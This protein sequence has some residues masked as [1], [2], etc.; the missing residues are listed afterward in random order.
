MPWLLTAPI[1]PLRTPDGHLRIKARQR[2]DSPPAS[3]RPVLLATG[4]GTPRAATA[5]TRNSKPPAALPRAHSPKVR[6]L[7][8]VGTPSLCKPSA[9]FRE[10]ARARAGSGPGMPTQCPG[11][12]LHRQGHPKILSKIASQK[13]SSGPA[14]ERRTSAPPSAR[15]QGQPGTCPDRTRAIPCTVQAV[16]GCQPLCA[17]ADDVLDRPVNGGHSR[18]LPGSPVHRVTCLQA[19]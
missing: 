2:P 14:L 11:M 4:R 15:N 16:R 5:A 19:G 12:P 3:L 8:P 1:Q 6:G 17:T 7:W 18:S 9:L 13:A 10:G